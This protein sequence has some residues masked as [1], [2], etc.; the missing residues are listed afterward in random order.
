MSEEEFA[1]HK[2]GLATKRLEKPKKLGVKNVRKVNI[3]IENAS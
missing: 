2:D 3:Y 1:E